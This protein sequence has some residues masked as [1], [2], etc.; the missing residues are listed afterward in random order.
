MVRQADLKPA[1]FAGNV[2]HGGDGS[3]GHPLK[4]R[5]AARS[6]VE[7]DAGLMCGF[8]LDL[9]ASHGGEGDAGG[10]QQAQGHQEWSKER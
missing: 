5:G 2:H 8:E 6:V 3:R 10:Q 4:L 1:A 9:V 7:G